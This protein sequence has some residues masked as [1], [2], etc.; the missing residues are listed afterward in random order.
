MF[1]SCPP[2][3]EVHTWLPLL[4]VMFEDDLHDAPQADVIVHLFVDTRNHLIQFPPKMVENWL[5]NE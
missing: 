5:R 3:C 1:A 4:I 2:N